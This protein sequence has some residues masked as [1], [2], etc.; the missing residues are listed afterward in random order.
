MKHSQVKLIILKF[1]NKTIF[2]AKYLY[3]FLQIDSS[4][5]YQNKY[6]K[7]VDAQILTTI[8]K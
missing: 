8:E 3:L 6:W 7:S 5:L 2:S 4:G 1:K